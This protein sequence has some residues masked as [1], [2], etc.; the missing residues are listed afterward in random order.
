MYSYVIEIADSESDRGF[1][2]YAL[3]L[4]IFV[5]YHLLEY[6]RG[7]LGRRGHVQLGHNYSI[8]IFVSKIFNIF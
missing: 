6:A 5:F 2:S 8:Q 3:V 4:E 1:F 7:P